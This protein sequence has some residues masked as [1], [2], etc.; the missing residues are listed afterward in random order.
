MRFGYAC[1]NLCIPARSNHRC[2]LKNASPE[3]LRRLIR[4][5]L[6]GLREILEYNAARNILLFR[7]SSDII[8]FASH[9]INQVK[10]EAEFAPELSQLGEIVS[11]YE[12]VVSMHP[13]QYTIIN[14]PHLQVVQNSLAELNYHC[15]FLDALSS[16]SCHKIVIHVGGLYGNKARAKQRFIEQCR[17]MDPGLKRRL[18][19][20]NDDRLFTAADVLELSQQT[21]IPMVFDYLHHLANPSGP[22]QAA[23]WLVRARGTWKPHDGDYKVHYSEQDPQK[24]KGSHAQSIDIEKLRLFLA[25]LPDYRVNIM[26]EGKDK[27][28]S[29]ERVMA[30]FL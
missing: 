16:S 18:V 3:T 15:R 28:L 4:Q 24:K 17:D 13:G 27:N 6:N 20:E 21:C 8:P 5:N 2:L 10:W 11:K 1:L 7:I 23:E 22:I 26:L 19:I 30:A 12:M 25:E 14:S 9:P 29:V